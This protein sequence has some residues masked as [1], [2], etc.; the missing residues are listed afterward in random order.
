MFEA[1]TELIESIGS[2]FEQ[3]EKSMF[4]SLLGKGTAKHLRMQVF[5]CGFDSSPRQLLQTYKKDHVSC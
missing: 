3:Y 1:T 2:V 5:G 4:F